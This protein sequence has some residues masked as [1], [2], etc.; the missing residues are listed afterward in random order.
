MI[1]KTWSTH[2]LYFPWKLINGDCTSSYSAIET[3]TYVVKLLNSIFLWQPS[4]CTNCK[5]WSE[6][7]HLPIEK[8]SDAIIESAKHWKHPLSVNHS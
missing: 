5:G 3:V 4:T 6:Q 1:W 7:K 8:D 2:K